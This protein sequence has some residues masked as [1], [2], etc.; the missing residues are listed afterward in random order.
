MCIKCLVHC[1]AACKHPTFVTRIHGFPSKATLIF[2]WS[3]LLISSGIRLEAK[4][5]PINF[6]IQTLGSDLRQP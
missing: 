4:H 6:L 2:F 3:S 1:L 5:I